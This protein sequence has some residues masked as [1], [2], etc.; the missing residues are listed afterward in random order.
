M[1]LKG[2]ACLMCGRQ[3]VNQEEPGRRK[4]QAAELLLGEQK[5][6]V[7]EDGGPVR[8]DRQVRREPWARPQSDKD[9]MDYL[10]R[11]GLGS[12]PEK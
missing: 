4:Q 9:S 3:D 6:G 7:W 10:Q 11:G 1:G 8:R 2:E 12:D 5:E